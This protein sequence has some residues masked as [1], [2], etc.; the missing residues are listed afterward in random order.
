M[1]RPMNDQYSDH[2]ATQRRNA[3]KRRI[4]VASAICPTGLCEALLL[5][6]QNKGHQE[7]YLTFFRGL[8]QPTE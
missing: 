1:D 8:W 2:E 4:S 3:F 5:A 6:P 7:R